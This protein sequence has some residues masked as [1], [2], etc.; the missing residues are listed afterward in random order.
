MSL[1]NVMWSRPPMT[2]NILLSDDAG[3]AVREQSITVVPR[4]RK[5]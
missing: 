4:L 3:N 5:R 1:K 2:H